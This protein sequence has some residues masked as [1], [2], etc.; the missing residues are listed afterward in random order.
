MAASWPPT[1]GAI[2]TWVVRTTPIRGVVRPDGKRRYIA[3]PAAAV[4]MNAMTLYSCFR[5]AIYAPPL[6]ES[7]RRHR[8]DEI[9]NG[10]E[11]EAAPVVHYVPQAC[12]ELVDAVDSVD[13]QIGGKDHSGG[14]HRLGDRFARPRETGREELRQAGAEEDECR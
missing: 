14:A 5:L 10:E 2:R 12:A 6:H 7:C 8:K 11:P 4:S 1:S 3:A 13:R 9:D